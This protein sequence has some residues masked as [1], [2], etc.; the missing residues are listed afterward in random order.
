MLVSVKNCIFTSQMAHSLAYF[1]PGSPDLSI[2]LDEVICNG[3]EES[4]LDCRTNPWGKNN[5][6]HQED[7]GVSCFEH[8]CM[9]KRVNKSSQITNVC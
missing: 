6:N 1:G 9:Y 8:K 5:C 7:A 4:L 3:S 2:V